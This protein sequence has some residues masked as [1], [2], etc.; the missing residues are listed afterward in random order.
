MWLCPF[1][2][3]HE[4]LLETIAFAAFEDCVGGTSLDAHQA[5]LNAMEYLQ[6]R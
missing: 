5:S 1:A 6:V 4:L 2:T 3:W